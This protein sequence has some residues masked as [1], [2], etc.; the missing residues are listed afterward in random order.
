M[1]HRHSRSVEVALREG[2]SGGGIQSKR[3]QNVV[4]QEAAFFSDARIPFLWSLGP[5][6]PGTLQLVKTAAGGSE[7]ETIRDVFFFWEF[8][9]NKWLTRLGYEHS[10]GLVSK[11]GYLSF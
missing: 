2:Q 11:V 3:D 4:S 10:E 7:G 1:D 9:G 8:K 5:G 6:Q